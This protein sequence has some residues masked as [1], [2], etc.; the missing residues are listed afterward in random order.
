MM[1]DRMARVMKAGTGAGVALLAATLPALAHPGHGPLTGFAAGVLHPLMGLD[2]LLAMVAVGLWAGLAGGSRAWLW[3]AT[4]VSSMAV[5]CALGLSDVVTVPAEPVIL[6]S[7]LA[8][9]VA[10]ASGLRAPLALGAA[11]IAV[12]GFAHGYAHGTE[13]PADANGLEFAGGFI[14]A[15][16]MLHAAGVGAAVTLAR[17]HRASIVRFAGVGIAMAGVGLIMGA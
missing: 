1:Q 3:P 13:M 8:L 15:T 17:A 7:V 9:G 2:H 10:V 11:L 6:A 4:F 12:F 16:A 5:G 14:L